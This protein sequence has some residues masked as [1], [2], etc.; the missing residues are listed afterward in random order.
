[1]KLTKLKLTQLNNVELRQDE[2]EHLIG[3]ESCG[4]ACKG[5]STTIDNANA[6]WYQ[7][8]STS[9]GGGNKLCGTWWT[10]WEWNNNHNS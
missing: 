7:G 9:I 4:C 10:D 3:A 1:M 6:N 5:P 8:Y 2:M